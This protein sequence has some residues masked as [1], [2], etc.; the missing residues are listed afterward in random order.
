M[1]LALSALTEGEDFWRHFKGSVE[2]SGLSGEAENA[3]ILYL[4]LTS[5]LF[6]HPVSLMIR[7]PAAC[8]KSYLLQRVIEHFP[9]DATIKAT[10]LSGKSLFL[11]NDGLAHRHVVF[12]EE[13]GLGGRK[14]QY[15]LR[16]LLS[17]G[18]I[19]WHAAENSKEGMRTRPYRQCGPTGLLV[20]STLDD[21]RTFLG[22]HMLTLQANASPEQTQA[23]MRLIASETPL[24]PIDPVWVEF[25]N[26]LAQGEI[27]V[28]VPFSD[29]LANS[30]NAKAIRMRRDFST[31]LSF[32]K[33]HAL[34]HRG[35]RQLD[36]QG[37][38]VA[39][40]E[41][42]LPVREMT[43][44]LF[45]WAS[46]L[47]VPDSVR[48]TMGAISYVSMFG[49]CQVKDVAL[50]LNIDRSSAYR[51][52]LT[53]IEHG[54]IE[55]ERGMRKKIENL[56]IIRQLPEGETALGGCVQVPADE[57]CNNN[58]ADISGTYKVK[59]AAVQ[60]ID[61]AGG[62]PAG[63]CGVNDQGPDPNCTAAQGGSTGAAEIA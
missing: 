19:V 34:L 31:L 29:V 16:T 51:R 14:Q 61:V 38:V 62:E 23:V 52:C 33:A 50:Y 5:R 58:N 39:V 63:G 13:H 53:A 8:G 41:D 36:D 45:S 9:A 3:Q 48:E 6:S 49:P 57:T 7:G 18:E 44:K 2:A 11:L 21:D 56:Q 40:M 46:G 15:L 30:C 59:E 35:S 12:A 47:A 60:S 43:E 1:G 27:R 20:T 17:E 26:W 22:S 32:V 54:L 42:Y 25:H 37:R 24:L 4:A 10:T 28:A 55:P